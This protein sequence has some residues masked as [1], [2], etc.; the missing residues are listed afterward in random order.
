MK[1]FRI[2]SPCLA[3]F[4]AVLVWGSPALRAATPE[5]APGI[6]LAHRVERLKV[7]LQ[8]GNQAAQETAAHEVELVRRTYGT[9]DVTPL[10]EAIA[11][12][13]RDL[14]DKGDPDLGLKAINL[15]EQRWAP[16]NP[17]ILGTRIVL[18]RQTGIAGYVLSLPDVTELTRIRLSHTTHR[19]L[20]IVHHAAWLRMMATLLLWGW[21]LALALRYR[22]V[23]RY[24]WEEPLAKR[25]IG[26]FPMALMGAFLLTFPVILG[27]DP[28]VAALLWIWLL[29]PYLHSQEVKATYLVILLQLVH[30]ALAILEPNA[31]QLP[32]PSIVTMQ[33]QPQAKAMDEATLRALPSADRDFLKG[34][35][36]FQA[37]DWKGAEAT[38]EALVGKHPNQAE[39]L[40]NLGAARFQQGR[41]AEAEKN[42]DE[43]YALQPGSPQILLN[44]S[45][46]AFK[47]LD[48]PN[49]IAKQEEARRSA[50]ESYEV[51]KNASQAGTEPRAFALPLPDSTLRSDAL[52]AGR[53]TV[54]A[55]ESLGA[56][57]PSI[58]FGLALPI[59]AL[60][61]YMVRLARSIKQ[62][63]PTQ[64]V[65]C[66]DPFHTTD[67]PDVEV[68][69]K[70]HH[71]FV[72]KDGLHGESRKQKV[73][74]V[75]EF[76][77]TQRWIHRTL[78]V[79]LPGADLCF[80]G[81]TRQGFMELIFLCFASGI[82]FTT[83]R[84][85]R[86]SGEIL[87]DPTSTWL[88]LGMILLAVL[89]FRSWLKLIPRRGRA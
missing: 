77:G 9:L 12:W 66:G 35:G 44:Q 49:G 63:H 56:R 32:E 87:A 51:L 48:S 61:A 27:F 82:V 30:P 67:S 45:A 21:A 29:T 18:L 2:L 75:A 38:F 88:P 50:P 58:L 80:L 5:L 81:D 52:K 4:L 54:N 73:E 42:L 65:R 10:V 53:G 20:W 7:A 89:F 46:M 74:E 70:C 11:V 71:L 79:V 34:W 24:L 13:A 64:C 1:V 23:L 85:V 60:L 14:G 43:A 6:A 59:F 39:V 69:S 86:F 84:S 57:T 83:G 25:G 33:L 41:V 19:W 78:L 72:L 15:V 40:N 36:Q 62:A 22:K 47:K 17:T 8:S 37:R 31:L 3:L 26:S 68:C 16:R 76:Q 28:S 55:M